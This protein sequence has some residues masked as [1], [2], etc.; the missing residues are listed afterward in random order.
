MKLNFDPHILLSHVEALLPMLTRM[1]EN[2]RP[3]G[4]QLTVSSYRKLFKLSR[5]RW[6]VFIVRL[7]LH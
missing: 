1:I 5:S 2:K 4:Q 6:C 3:L 7:E